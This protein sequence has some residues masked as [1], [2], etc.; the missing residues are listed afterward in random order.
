M[1]FLIHKI[2]ERPKHA[3]NSDSDSALLHELFGENISKCMGIARPKYSKRTCELSICSKWCSKHSLSL[4]KFP[5]TVAIL[6]FT[7]I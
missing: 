6:T 1:N 4:A 3:D 7:E 2:P 5:Q